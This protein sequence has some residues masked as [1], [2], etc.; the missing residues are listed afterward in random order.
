MSENTMVIEDGH[1]S[2]VVDTTEI[3]GDPPAVNTKPVKTKASK[4]KV[5]APAEYIPAHQPRIRI[6]L[7]E[8]DNIPPTGLFIGVNGTSYLL[9]PG[10]E[11]AVPAAVVEALNDAVEDV[12]R[13]DQA[14]NVVDYR[15][16]MRFPYRILSK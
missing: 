6:I 9:R 11:V 14:N 8:N 5:E 10:E 13:L 3:A 16:K 1:E 7:E 4:P 2:D 12:P 15:K